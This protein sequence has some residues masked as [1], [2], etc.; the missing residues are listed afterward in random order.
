MEVVDLGPLLDIQIGCLAKSDGELLWSHHLL[1]RAVAARMAEYIPSITHQE[2]RVLELAALTHDIGKVAGEVQEYLKGSRAGPVSHKLSRAQYGELVGPAAVKASFR[3]D[4]ILRAWEVL[5]C[6]H[7]VSE[8]DI[9]ETSSPRIAKL[10]QVLIEADHMASMRRPDAAT[11]DDVRMKHQGVFDLTY[12]QFSRFPSP[13]MDLALQSVVKL[14]RDLEWQPLLFL[15]DSAI[16]IGKPGLERPSKKAAV[17][18]AARTIVE[19]T[20]QRRGLEIKAYTNSVLGGI[21]AEAPSQLVDRNRD[22]LLGKLSDGAVAPLYFLKLA[23]EILN[24]SKLIAGMRKKSRLLEL[25]ALANSTSS[26][27][28]AKA[29]YAKSY[30]RPLPESIDNTF[31]APFFSEETVDAF[32]PGL[33]ELTQYEGLTPRKLSADQLYDIL[34]KLARRVETENPAIRTGIEENLAVWL[35]MEEE[36]DFAS[37]ARDQFARYVDYKSSFSYGRGSCERCASTIPIAITEADRFD[38]KIKVASQIKAKYGTERALCPFCVLDNLVSSADGKRCFLHLFTTI[39]ADGPSFDQIGL[40]VRKLVSGLRNPRRFK[41]GH[42]IGSLGGLPLPGRLRF[43]WPESDEDGAHHVRLVPRGE[44]GVLIELQNWKKDSHKDLA[45][46]YE[47]AYH[48]LRIMGFDIAIGKDEQEGL[49]GTYPLSDE[50]AYHASLAVVLMA[51]STGKQSNK[52]LFAKD[53]LQARPAVALAA[54]FSDDER[55]G[56]RMAEDLLPYFVDFVRN[57]GLIV[58]RWRGGNMT[59]LRLLDD[60]AFLADREHGMFCYCEGPTAGNW[61]DSKHAASK[62]I[63]QALRQ[64]LNGRGLDIAKQTFRNHLSPYIGHDDAGLRSF[65]DRVDRI[66]EDYYAI[67]QADITQFLRTKNALIAAVY[68]FTRYPTLMKTEEAEDVHHAQ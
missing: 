45:A 7:Y 9:L 35:A 65:I 8:Q 23:F 47:P 38:D 28:K 61:W 34:I 20:L 19:E 41:V 56:P 58:A 22:L 3:D 6:H 29:Y 30:D 64:V 12:L 16:M 18:E 66:I 55:R 50:H 37:Y 40:F 27:P 13:T 1:V 68:T 48:L 17:G 33:S 25:L 5:A 24:C 60:A 4:E 15:T 31:F 62:P 53:L 51:N 57:S 42:E 21:A 10:T 26:H 32:L 2:K 52:Y 46:K 14:Y 54:A 39:P 36:I 63:A 44:R 11:I 49:F 59:M 67:R 43:P